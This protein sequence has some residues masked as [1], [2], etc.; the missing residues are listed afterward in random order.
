MPLPILIVENDES[1]PVGRVRDWLR[2][3]GAEL[4]VVR[5]WAGEPIPA[6]LAGVG[7]LVVL[8]GEQAAYSDDGFGWRV[9]L[10]RLLRTAV[11][12]Q[13]P[14]LGL[15]LGGQ[16]LAVATGGRVEPGRNGIE[17]GWGLIARR[18]ASYDDPVFDTLPMTPDVLHF[19][20]DE[21]SQ[22]PPGAVHLASGPQYAHQAFRV[23]PRAWGTQ[24][25]IETEPET[26]LD[27]VGDNLGLLSGIDVD[28]MVDRAMLAHDA[29]PDTW[30]PFAAAFVATTREP[31]GR[32]AE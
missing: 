24:F 16:L 29:M 13:L 32:P 11:N 8:G 21:I 6:D 2:D 27:W 15:C 9:E 20:L 22:L 17:I 28:P 30:R 1:D 12:E 4:R 18:D 10:L 14:T 5:A 25:H 23:G 19:H 3:A 31:V 26:F 7:G